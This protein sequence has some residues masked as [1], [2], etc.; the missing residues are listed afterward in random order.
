MTMSTVKKSHR[1]RIRASSKL[2]VSELIR[3]GLDDSGMTNVEFSQRLG[4]DKPNVIAMIKKG[5]MRLPHS[6]VL[7]AS[8]ALGLDPVFLLRKVITESDAELW[9]SIEKIMGDAFVSAEEMKLI[10]FIRERSQGL[11]VRLTEDPA[12]V[13]AIGGLVDQAVVRNEALIQGAKDRI[14]RSKAAKAA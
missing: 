1:E 11:D 6:K 5:D 2:S 14:E 3:L 9:A 4:Y 8:Q 10:Q 7:A 13:E 12:A